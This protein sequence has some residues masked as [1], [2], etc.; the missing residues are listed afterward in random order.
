M[1]D[2]NR[3]SF[4]ATLAAA[5]PALAIAPRA[6]HALTQP[7]AA[8][9]GAAPLMVPPTGLWA[10]LDHVTDGTDPSTAIIAPPRFTADIKA[11]EGKEITLTGYLQPVSIGFGKSRDYL[12]SRATFHCAFCYA[13]G[14][15]SLALATIDGHAPPG[16]GKVTVRGTLSLQDKDPSDFY[17]QLR[18]ARIG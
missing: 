1:T 8:D 9:T 14:R 18:K 11:M 4:L 17:F 2:A 16:N 10:T 15:G 13:S 3:R 12:L 6:A 7:S 5:L